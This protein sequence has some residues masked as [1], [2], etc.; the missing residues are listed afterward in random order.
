MTDRHPDLETLER[1][2][3]DA[4][5]EPASRALQ[6]HVLICPRCEERL[7]ALLPGP[8]SP[9]SPVH[10]HRGLIQRL[11]DDHRAEISKRRQLVAVERGEASGLWRELEPLGQEERRARVWENPRYQ[12]WGL[13]EH[14]VETSQ[15]AVLEEPRKAE[16]LLRLA[17]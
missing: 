14:L 17:L 13:F 9:P 1:F 3:E 11:L 7:T 16:S 4:L 6:R 8:A 12:S 2:L 15:T 5:S 10:G